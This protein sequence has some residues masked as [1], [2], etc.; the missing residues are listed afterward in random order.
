MP[1]FI[2]N[3]W[4]HPKSTLEGTVWGVAI[5]A[6]MT[7]VFASFHCSIP[8]DFSFLPWALGGIAVIRGAMA[9]GAKPKA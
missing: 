7:Y 1:Q 5:V 9:A 3:L 6:G 8:D 4:E 2:K